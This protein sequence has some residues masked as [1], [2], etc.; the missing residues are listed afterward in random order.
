MT[1]NLDSSNILGYDLYIRLFLYIILIIGVLIHNEIIVINICGLA[2]DTKYFLD[3]K[4]KNEELYSDADEP[5]ILQRFET[6]E[7]E[8]KNKNDDLKIN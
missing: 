7:L 6:I 3:L 4:V 1:D 2:S 5:E 8:D